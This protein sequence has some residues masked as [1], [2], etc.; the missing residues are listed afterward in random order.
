MDLQI[1][2]PDILNG[3]FEL[4]GSIMLWN[5]VRAIYKDKAVQGV[6]VSS[7]AF[8]MLW[9]YW[10]MFYYPHLDQWWSFLGGCSITLANSVWVGQMVYY[11]RSKK[12]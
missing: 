4:G 12:S 5:N 3:I 11:S 10:N 7:T 2:T 9:G 8:F 1:L 6:R